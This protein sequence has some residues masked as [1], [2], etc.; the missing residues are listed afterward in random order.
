M[1]YYGGFIPQYLERYGLLL[2]EVCKSRFI[3]KCFC[4]IS[5]PRLLTYSNSLNFDQKLLAE[6]FRK[7]SVTHVLAE[8]GNCSVEI[9]DVCEILRIKLISHFHGYEISRYD[10][11]ELYKDRY[12]ILFQKSFKVI[13]VSKLMQKR[14]LDL[15][16]PSDKLV[17]CPCGPDDSLLN[18]KPALIGNNIL[19]VGRFVD[20]K[21]PYDLI[22]AFKEVSAV[23]PDST[24]TMIG[25]G[26]LYDCCKHL[27]TYYGLR[28]RINFE[29]VVEHSRIGEYYENASVYCQPS[30][31]ADS[32]D[33]EGTPVS[34]MEAS[35]ASLP[36]VAT[37][38]AGIV[39]VVKDGASGFLVD[40]HDVDELAKKL[41]E[42]LT[43]KDNAKRMGECG[44]IYVRD[45][46]VLS[47]SIG[48]LGKLLL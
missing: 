38:H 34:V 44:R 45:H 13:A 20:K 42:V 39:D 6:S 36:V 31:T 8:F 16:C 32:G 7:N 41:I 26:E 22:L 35:L 37:K 10:I 33:Q 12:R 48:E 40:E 18:L 17:Y 30:V 47:K 23:I 46:F 24:L 25:I 9:M 28:D 29:G 14:I 4:I 19:Y 2:K 11:I 21:A 5:H 15:G 27:A 3:N 43:N 1:Y